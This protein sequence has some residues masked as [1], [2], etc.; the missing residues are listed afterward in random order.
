MK[1][2]IFLQARWLSNMLVNYQIGFEAGDGINRT[3]VLKP[4]RKN[5]ELQFCGIRQIAIKT[6]N[7]VL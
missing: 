7:E 3:K 1:N 2:K 4:F 5:P 6:L